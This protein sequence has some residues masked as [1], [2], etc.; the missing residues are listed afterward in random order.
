MR[1]IGKLQFRRLK[2]SLVVQRA[3]CRFEARKRISRNSESTIHS[4]SC[5]FRPRKAEIP[6]VVVGPRFAAFRITLLAVS[7]FGDFARGL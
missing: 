3:S 6:K 5:N 2:I 1:Q 4:E 7:V